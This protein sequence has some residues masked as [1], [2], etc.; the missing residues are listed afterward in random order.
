MMNSSISSAD[1]QRADSIPPDQLPQ[2]P[3]PVPGWQ[4][5]QTHH[6]IASIEQ[7]AT[8]A[9]FHAQQQF[10][11]ASPV[12]L[13]SNESVTPLGNHQFAS[14]PPRPGDSV[15]QIT[16]P[17]YPHSTQE[18]MV[19]TASGPMSSNVIVP[20]R[21]R[22]GRKPIPQEDAADR[23]RLQNRIAQ[24]NF[25]DKR[26]QKLAETLHEL[27]QNKRSYRSKQ[28]D[29]ERELEALHQQQRTV[30]ERLNR[31]KRRAE[32]AER[33]A[34][35]AE[36]RAQ[37]LEK[38]L[39]TAQGGQ[40]PATVP[41]SLR[42]YTGF[43]PSHH[44]HA[45]V[46]TPPEDNTYETD[47]TNYGR[48]NSSITQNALRSS[49]GNESSSQQM[50][51]SVDENDH[52]GFCTDDQ[53][54]ACKQDKAEEVVTVPGSC[55][56]CRTDPQRAQACREMASSAR[57]SSRP[58]STEIY[59]ESS[60]RAPASASSSSLSMP[61]PPPR[62]S[63]SAM[64]D[65]FNHYGE[66]PASISNLYGGQLNAYPAPSGGYEFEEQQAAEV[67]SNLSR[68]S[69]VADSRE[70]EETREDSHQSSSED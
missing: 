49:T 38:Q 1:D 11:S 12:Q 56:A 14:L 25:R 33:R 68:R 53:N 52:C 59:E 34:I 37:H 66:R 10:P 61:P 44:A 41:N 67:L 18:P 22:P 51:F 55:D 2:Q 24:R 32:N 29:M 50:D 28:N 3:V 60:S 31:E 35:L 45:S 57:M 69:T 30:S 19:V 36:S 39:K 21:P 62:M 8:D 42:T 47:F 5:T 13:S 63:C 58:E 4:S 26:Q 16:S 15:T 65:Q 6:A 70:S 23:R 17:Q 7:Q 27:E 40:L 64:V 46:P 43:Q 48:S 54:C 20:Q 9:A